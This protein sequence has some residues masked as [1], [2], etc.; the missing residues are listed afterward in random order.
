MCYFLH[1]HLDFRVAEFQALADLAGVGHQVQWRKPFGDVE[2]S[3]FWYVWLPSVGATARGCT[4]RRTPGSR[5]KAR[6]RGGGGMAAGW[7]PTR[8]RGGARHPPTITSHQQS[9]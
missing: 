1:R 6:A 5:L 7:T 9:T 2:H 8:A 4:A 3:P